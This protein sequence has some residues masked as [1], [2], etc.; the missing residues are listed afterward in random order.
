M[1][2][3]Q[4]KVVSFFECLTKQ[5][6]HVDKQICWVP[7]MPYICSGWLTHRSQ[8]I[9]YR[10]RLLPLLYDVFITGYL[11][12]KNP[13]KF[14]SVLEKLKY[15]INSYDMDYDFKMIVF[16]TIDD[17][18][19]EAKSSYEFETKICKL[20]RS[21]KVLILDYDLLYQNNDLR[22]FHV[23]ISDLAE[24]AYQM[25]YVYTT[26]VENF[27]KLE[28][29]IKETILKLPVLDSDKSKIEEF[30]NNTVLHGLSQLYL[31]YWWKEL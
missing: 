5:I 9:Q 11:H 24:K 12:A 18:Y 31:M 17:V 3:K 19:H 21:A 22:K 7:I 2:S 30:I 27:K 26:D 20:K 6:K 15:I 8:L 23:I 29:E 13:K 14:D 25:G 1:F 28:I 16:D 10:Q 4:D